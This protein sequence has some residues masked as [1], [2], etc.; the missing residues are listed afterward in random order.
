[1]RAVERTTSIAIQR[2]VTSLALQYSVPCKKLTILKWV[3]KTEQVWTAF[4]G[5]ET[6][7]NS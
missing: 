5:L 6:V 3:L 2:P 7:S 4:M 1:M